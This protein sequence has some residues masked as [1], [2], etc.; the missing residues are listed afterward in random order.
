[1]ALR[2]R[3]SGGGAAVTV[4]RSLAYNS[5]L[6][7]RHHRSTKK[8]TVLIDA[9]LLAAPNTPRL[10]AGYAGPQLLTM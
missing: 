7:C 10:Y 5:C 4:L 3:T 1:M 6:F 2:A 8:V 9:H